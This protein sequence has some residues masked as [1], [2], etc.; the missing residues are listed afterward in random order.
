M[1]DVAGIDQTEA[2]AAVDR[3]G[4][5]GVAQLRLGALDRGLVGL[6][7]GLELIDLGLLLIDSLLRA[8]AFVHQVLEACE[9]LLVGN[10][11]GLVLGALGVG[12]VERGLERPS[13]DDCERVAFLDVLAFGEIHDLQLAVD[14][15]ADGDGIR[16]LHRAEPVEIDR[17]VPCRNF[18]C[19]DRNRRGLRLCWCRRC[20][21]RGPAFKAED[22]SQSQRAN[23]AKPCELRSS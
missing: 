20:L 12:L 17:H 19:G 18:Y 15:A 8:D 1:H 16:R 14:L 13:I 11:L 10:E 2:D 22:R 21:L 23:P 7:G 4:D 9:I 3:R 5:G 6:D